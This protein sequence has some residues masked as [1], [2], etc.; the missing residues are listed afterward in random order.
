VRLAQS[1]RVGYSSQDW[2]VEGGEAYFIDLNPAGQWLFLPEPVA[3]EVS[4]EIAAWLT[5]PVG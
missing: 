4:G 5:A 1:A 3:S 2:I